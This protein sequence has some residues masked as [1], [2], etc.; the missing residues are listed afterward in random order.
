MKPKIIV[1]GSLNMDL[2]VRSPHIPA[3]GET[4]LGSTFATA[5][6]GKG[7]N[8]AVAAARLGARVSMVG[9]VGDDSYGDVLLQSLQS[10]GVDTRFVQRD[11]NQ[12]TGLALITV[13]DH[14][15]NSIVVVSG[16]NWQ[17]STADIERAA[18]EIANADALVLQLEIPL[19]SVEYA[20]R[21]A[22]QRQIPVIL[23]PA[24]AQALPASLLQHVAYLVPNESEA[25]LLSGTTVT[26]SHTAQEAIARIRQSGVNTVIMT[27][28]S[29][30]A[31]VSGASG[32]YSVPAFQ[33]NPVDTTAAGDAFVA[34]LAFGIASNQPLKQAVRL[35]A[36][37]G[38]LATT[39]PGAQPS[40]PNAAQVERLLCGLSQE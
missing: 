9:R 10:D 27:R 2:I 29:Q 22:H 32:T 28:G 15:E 19:E 33:V 17:V 14:G 26:D 7:A 39:K 36:A 38:A 31:F 20:V 37:A 13:D 8:Q 4:V 21:L 12:P 11:P 34:G 5:G 23:N 40:L 18:D 1:I 3:P 16:A 35:A 30:G 25:A 24:P 6:G